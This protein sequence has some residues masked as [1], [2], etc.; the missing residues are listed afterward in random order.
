V[1]YLLLASRE[2]C[3]DV[4]SYSIPLQGP[5]SS[6]RSQKQRYLYRRL[7]VSKVLIQV[8][9][10]VVLWHWNNHSLFGGGKS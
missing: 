1:R 5:V 7:V 2:V 4:C 3:F 10:H 8:I 6:L 9:V